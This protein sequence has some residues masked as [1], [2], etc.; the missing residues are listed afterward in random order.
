MPI[1]KPIVQFGD[2][3]LPPRFWEKVRQDKLGCW[4]WTAAKIHG[5]GAY[6]PV[7]KQTGRAHRIA[8][9]ALVGPV[10]AESIDHLC[11]ERACVN[12][13][14]LEPCSNRENTLR[15]YGPSA[16]NAR[17]SYC[18]RGHPFAEDVI[19]REPRRPNS[20]TCRSCRRIRDR[21]RYPRKVRNAAVAP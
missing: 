9:E 15:G 13:A 2:P 8:Y 5:Y 4:M 16:I 20:R 21:N 17:K 3:R 10:N 6:F 19:Y 11:R 18:K 14:H 1:A 12:P 7:H